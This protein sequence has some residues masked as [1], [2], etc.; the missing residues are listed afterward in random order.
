MDDTPNS[1]QATGRVRITQLDGLRGIAIAMVFVYHAYAVPGLWMGVDL[2][3]VLSGF[4]I[5]GILFNQKNKSFG[6]Y[7]RHFYARRARRILPPYVVVLIITGLIFGFGFLH[8]WYMYFGLMNFQGTTALPAGPKYLPLWSLA[9]EEQFYFV[10]PLVVFLLSRRQLVGCVCG[11]IVLAPVLRF[12]CTPLFSDPGPIYQWLPFR[13]DTLAMGALIALVWPKL[14]AKMEVLPKLRHGVAVAGV[15]VIFAGFGVLMAM[16]HYGYKLTAN[17][18][19]GNTAEYSVVVAV[20]GS[21]LLLALLGV[22][23]RILDLWPLVW[24]GRISFSFYLIHLTVLHFVPWHSPL[25]ALAVSL[26][27]CVAMWFAVEKPLTD[28]GQNREKVLV[29]LRNVPFR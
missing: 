7:I 25:I 14:K 6:S 26:A 27:Y 12:F 19:A 13:M 3:F 23:K 18:R 17:T 2:F 15:A 20:M 8:H 9:V 24:L 4:L 11:L 16:H 1:R 5:T 29:P 10:W 22:G 28:P 21:A